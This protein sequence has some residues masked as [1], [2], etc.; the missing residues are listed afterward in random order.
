[1]DRERAESELRVDFRVQRSRVYALSSRLC[2]VSPYFYTVRSL[3]V[4]DVAGVPKLGCNAQVFATA[5]ESVRLGA[6]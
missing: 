4:A 6:F 3:E 5:H 2:I 1:M